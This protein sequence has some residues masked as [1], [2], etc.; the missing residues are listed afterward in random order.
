MT[1]LLNGTLTVMA[2]QVFDGTTMDTPPDQCQAPQG[3]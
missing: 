1:G 3:S 2:H